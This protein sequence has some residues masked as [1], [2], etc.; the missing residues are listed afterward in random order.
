MSQDQILIQL[1]MSEKT[2]FGKEDFALQSAPQK[3]FSAIWALEDEVNNGGFSQYF[4]NLSNET[5]G[6]VCEALQT[7]GA[8]KTADICKRAIEAAFPDGLP[9]DPEEI[10]QVA[11]GFLVEIEDKLNDLD[12]EFYTY[13]HRLSDLLYR[14]VYQHSE[15]FGE[16]PEPENK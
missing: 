6:Y 11:A 13:P 5:A 15:E 7:I 2:Q 16:V 12:E 14:F 3:V 1:S 8:P 9:S 10:G 4:A